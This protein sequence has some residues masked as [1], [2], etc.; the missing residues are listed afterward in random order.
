MAGQGMGIR[1]AAAAI[2]A[3]VGAGLFTYAGARMQGASRSSAAGLGLK[4]ASV[5][6]GFGLVAVGGAVAGAGMAVGGGALALAGGGSIGA[7]AAGSLAVAGT[8]AIYAGGRAEVAYSR[9]H[10]N[11]SGSRPVDTRAPSR[12]ELKKF[13]ERN[14]YAD[15]HAFKKAVL[16]TDNAR[17]SRWIIR[18]DKNTREVLLEPVQGGEPM[19]TGFNL[20]R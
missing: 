10:N 11:S 2:G 1:A 3:T 4:A 14:G 17:V 12:S 19:G 15:E 20:F 7:G 8:G 13:L 16:G 18:V 9:A 5:T 6:A